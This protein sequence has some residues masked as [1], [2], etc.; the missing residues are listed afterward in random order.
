M[1]DGATTRETPQKGFSKG[2]DM[3]TAYRTALVTGI[4]SSL[5]GLAACATGNDDMADAPGF[6]SDGTTGPADPADTDAQ[7]TGITGTPD[8]EDPVASTGEVEG[9][10]EDDGEDTDGPVDGETGD[11]EDTDGEETGETGAVLPEA[12]DDGDNP[13]EPAL[14][15]QFRNTSP[16]PLS[17]DAPLFNTDPIDTQG[18]QY[19]EAVSIPGD[20]LDVI[21]FQIVPGQVDPYV[22]IELEC[23]APE[24]A[25][26]RAHLYDDGG[27]LLDTV[28][29]GEG[30]VDVLLKAASSVD[31]YQVQVELLDGDPQ[32]VH[33]T[34][35]VDGFCFQQ[36]DYAPYVP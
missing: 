4:Y 33:Y 18:G 16:A 36:C 8:D 24:Q 10:T 19:S 27:A 15:L 17:F 11:V 13:S 20:E 26:P 7:T 6:S 34:L 1:Q 22:G 25:R 2:I 5:L 23:D 3:K 31:V 32:L 21:A 12:P 29:C 9:D 35:S 14:L 30:E 28:S